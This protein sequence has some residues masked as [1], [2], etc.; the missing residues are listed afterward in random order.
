MFKK[1]FDPFARAEKAL[2]VFQKSVDELREV[3]AD[4]HAVADAAF[5]QS[6]ELLDTASAHKAAAYKHEKRI[7]KISEFLA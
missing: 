6:S 2:A 3:V 1:K 5:E 4:H 7:N